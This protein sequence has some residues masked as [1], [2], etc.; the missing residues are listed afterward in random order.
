[1]SDTS[2]DANRWSWVTP[3]GKTVTGAKGE[4]MLALRGEKLPAS[5]LVSRPGW[6]EWLPA[7]RVAELRNVLP[8]GKAEPAQAPKLAAANAK[9]ILPTL[10]GQPSPAVAASASSRPP[11][12][13]VR[14]KTSRPPPAPVRQPKPQGAAP[15]GVATSQPAPVPAGNVPATASR[16]AAP[17]AMRAAAAPATAP[18]AVPVYAAA[19]VMAPPVVVAAPVIAAPPPVIVPAPVPPATVKDARRAEATASRAPAIAP[20][21]VAPSMVDTRPRGASL[22]GPPREELVNS[23]LGRG[24]LP[25]LADQETEQPL[26]T[27]RPP[28]AV[29]PP[30]RVGVTPLLG[31]PTPKG[32]DELPTQL[33]LPQPRLAP[34]T[35]AN[36]DSRARAENRAGA[37]A[38]HAPAAR[39]TATNGLDATLG[40]FEAR[41]GD[42]ARPG[43]AVES[44][45]PSVEPADNRDGLS[46]TL[47][48]PRSVVIVLAVFLSGVLLL[49]GAAWVFPSH[50]AGTKAVASTDA[51]AAPAPTEAPGCRLLAPAAR[52]ATTVERSVQPALAEIVPDERVAVGFAAAA[53][54]G[55]GA[56]IRL[57]TLDAER[58]PDQ[59]GDAVVRTSAPLIKNGTASFAID[60]TSAELGG[61]RTLPDGTTVGFAGADLVAKAHGK[62]SVLV[63]GAA[64]EKTTDPRVASSTGGTLVTFR[65]GGLSGQVLYTWIGANGA[66]TTP[67]EP[68][69]VPDVKFAGTPDGA[70]SSTGGLIAFAGRPSDTAEWRVKLVRVPFSGQATA[71]AFVAPAGGSGGGNIAPAV[72]ALGDNGWL[73]QWTEGA[74]GAYQVRLQRLNAKLEPVGDARLVSPKGANAG[75]GA[76]IATG[77]HVLSVYIQT[78]AGHD[79]LWGASFE[80]K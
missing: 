25:T 26:G 68:V 39:A 31:T 73:L 36:P 2:D 72:S 50:G 51:S 74:A 54:V 76:V 35:D 64:S 19:P 53:K 59:T 43:H 22:L 80:C 47:P 69:A 48:L 6:A 4:L 15:V 79:E 55:A 20:S 62:T 78:T 30:P 71:Q 67:L 17:T 44:T 40:S 65:R 24:P 56:I 16:G 10:R 3:D 28:G 13:P 77:S 38:T 27:L 75:Q 63:A 57:D 12:P 21:A 37:L 7:S 8:P 14:A 52:L 58:R 1:M 49:G 11:P 60:R 42:V 66:V 23:A 34:T 45:G 46:W 32:D 9:T 41:S 18:T 5:T 29:P 33:Y 70:A 61:A